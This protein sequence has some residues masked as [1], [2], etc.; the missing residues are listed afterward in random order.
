[1][2]IMRRCLGY[3]GQRCGTLLEHGTRCTIHSRMVNRAEMTT[4]HTRRPDFRADQQRRAVAV[5]Q[6]RARWGD[7]CPGWRRPG[8]IAADLTADHPTSVARGGD[9][10][11]PLEVLCHSCNSAKS[12]D[13]DRA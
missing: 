9:E 5:A 6:H 1:M 13:G 2:P 7:W 3:Q 8:H 10:R 11:G 12:D 4:R